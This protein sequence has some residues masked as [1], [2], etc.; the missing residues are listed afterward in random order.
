PAKRRGPKARGPVPAIEPGVLT[1][2]R[3][4]ESNHDSG[5][6]S[7]LSYLWTTPEEEP[8][9]PSTGYAES[10]G[11]TLARDARVSGRCSSRE[12]GCDGARHRTRLPDAIRNADAVVRG[13][14]YVEPG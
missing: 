10:R 7:P 13:S 1:W 11:A 4:V 6:Q 3:R 12:F 5:I 2:F 8:G 14:C 9:E